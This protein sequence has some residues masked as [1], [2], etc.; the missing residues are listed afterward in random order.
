MTFSGGGRI[1][2]KNH[3]HNANSQQGGDLDHQVTIV[4]FSDEDVPENQRLKIPLE[5][6]L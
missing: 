6:F 4:N 5:A 3:Y 2:L 1:T